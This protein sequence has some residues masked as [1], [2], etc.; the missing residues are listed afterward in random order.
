M[1][2]GYYAMK[3]VSPATMF[4]EMSKQML[5]YE[6]KFSSIDNTLIVYG[7]D[8][9]YNKQAINDNRNMIDEVQRIQRQ[10]IETSYISVKSFIV[11]HDIDMNTID[12]AHLGRVCYEPMGTNRVG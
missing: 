11:Y 7:Q 8:I 10:L 2:K 6:R 1:N 9:N 5:E 4:M 12:P 3:E